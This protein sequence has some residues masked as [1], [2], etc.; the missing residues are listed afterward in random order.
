MT[1]QSRGYSYEDFLLDPTK[2]R[3]FRSQRGS[4][5][6]SLEGEEYTDLKIRRAFPFEQANSFIGVFDSNGD[7]LGLLEDPQ[8]LD[9]DSRQALLDELDKIY[10][11]PK[12]LTFSNLDEEYGVLRG[13]IET[14]SGPRQLEI[15]NYRTNVRMLSGG[16]AIVE[17][18]D[19]NRYLIED[20]RALPQHTRE[21][22]GL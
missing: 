20:W 10:F 17:D 22:L 13:Q 16:R 18:V 11:H 1:K 9:D 4:L 14:S 7:E 5:I 19:G 8:T 3:F 2:M 12:I 21:I 15:R 6:L